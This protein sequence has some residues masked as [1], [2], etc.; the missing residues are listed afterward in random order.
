MAVMLAVKISAQWFSLL[1]AIIV[2]T[3][4]LV[5]LLTADCGGLA[6]DR[7]I[8]ADVPMN[9]SGEGSAYWTS[10]PAGL[11]ECRA[12][13]RLLARHALKVCPV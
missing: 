13:G 8:F 7:E 12:A 4:G 11:D 1:I 10:T 6:I 5:T 3:M 2:L 9:A